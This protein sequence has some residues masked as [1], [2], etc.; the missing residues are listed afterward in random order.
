[1]QSTC[2]DRGGKGEKKKMINSIDNFM[3]NMLE[4]LPMVKETYY[5]NLKNGERLDT[6]VIEDIFMPEIIRLLLN[7]ENEDLLKRMFQYIEA[8][9]NNNL[10]L[11]DILSITLFE[12]LGNDKDILNKA[13]RYMGDNSKML[14]IEADKQLGRI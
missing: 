6:V 9:L 2:F 1:M 14:Q 7:D 5:E 12:I 8:T 10:Y 3:I 11:R 4:F 13:N